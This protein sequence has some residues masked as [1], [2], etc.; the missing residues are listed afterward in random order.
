MLIIIRKDSKYSSMRRVSFGRAWRW[1]LW[2]K[3]NQASVR[4]CR[5]RGARELHRGAEDQPGHGGRPLRG[6][7]RLQPHRLHGGAPGRQGGVPPGLGGHW[8]GRG[9]CALLHLGS[10]IPLPNLTHSCQVRGAIR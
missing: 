2:A 7:A 6:G 1:S 9:P 8:P 5:A 3:P 10:D 4:G